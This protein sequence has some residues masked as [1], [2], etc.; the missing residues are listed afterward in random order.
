[1]HSKK[2]NDDTL[3]WRMKRPFQITVLRSEDA[4]TPF[5]PG[6]AQP[7]VSAPSPRPVFGTAQQG[8]SAPLP[9]ASRLRSVAAYMPLAESTFRL[10]VRVDRGVGLTV[11]GGG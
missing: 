7:G 6:A 10:R 4:P 11:R 2:M 9:S 5:V 8:V 3:L 1:M